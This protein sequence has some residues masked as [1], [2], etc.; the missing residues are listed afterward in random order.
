MIYEDSSDN[1]NKNAKKYIEGF[2]KIMSAD[3]ESLAE[4][5]RDIRRYCD[6]DNPVQ[7]DDEAPS[8]QPQLDLVS[9]IDTDSYSY[10]NNP[11]NP[12]RIIVKHVAVAIES[13]VNNIVS[14]AFPSGLS[15]LVATSGDRD[16]DNLSGNFEYLD[17]A[18]KLIL[19]VFDNSNFINEVIPAITNSVNYGLGTMWVKEK[20][21]GRIGF[22]YVDYSVMLVSD[23]MDGMPDKVVMKLKYSGENFK[24]FLEE[25]GIPRPKDY[26]KIEDRTM[27][28]MD[29]FYTY[30]NKVNESL[31]K[32]TNKVI[33]GVYVKKLDYFA[34]F[35]KGY[36]EMPLLPFRFKKRGNPFGYGIGNLSASLSRMANRIADCILEAGQLNVKQ[37]FVSADDDIF[38]QLGDDNEIYPSTILFSDLARQGVPVLQPIHR[39]VN[40][41]FAWEQLDRTK[42]EIDQ[43]YYNNLFNNDKKA[44]QTGA[45]IF[46]I[47]SQRNRALGPSV[48]NIFTEMVIPIARIIYK[49]LK[50]NGL[51]G[52]VPEGL[53]GK[54]IKIA[55]KNQMFDSAGQETVNNI[56]TALQV[57]RSIFEMEPK[58]VKKVNAQKALDLIFTSLN[59]ERIL[60][61]DDDYDEILEEE[62]KMQAAND[63]Q[64]SDAMQSETELNQANAESAL[65]AK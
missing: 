33:S 46:D 42:E 47:K 37:S 31:F 6:F 57:S 54:N 40:L 28:E 61:T 5:D 12:N 39:E 51:L 4:R 32:T 13:L 11:Y 2:I 15:W 58:S 62:D 27:Y 43:L 30:R 22:K 44:R 1:E 45:E 19:S 18:T 7:I 10:R 50:L 34:E 8:S 53:K 36:D 17:N 65:T 52:E 14:L 41:P 29:M 9:T 21:D 24:L 3:K 38:D 49:R 26:D 63:Q 48:I 59:I 23:G 55:I 35:E 56:L 16:T 20:S 64:K 60:E 25:Y